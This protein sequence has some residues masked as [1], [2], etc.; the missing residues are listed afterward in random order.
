[1]ESPEN[2]IFNL[3]VTPFFV[4]TPPAEIIGRLQFLEIILNSSFEDRHPACPPA[5][6]FTAISASAPSPSTFLAY[7]SST[8]SQ[9]TF[10]PFG[11][12]CWITCLGFPSEVIIKSTSNLIQLS[13]C[14][15]NF[16]ACRNNVCQ[17]DDS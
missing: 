12:H 13:N 11:L 4:P 6:L 9:K 17:H 8:T 3:S 14:F 5:F 1:M 7:S 10:I 15:F 16:S 2:P